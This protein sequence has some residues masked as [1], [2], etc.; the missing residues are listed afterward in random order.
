MGFFVA[1]PLKTKIYVYNKEWNNSAMGAISQKVQI[2]NQ[3]FTFS[4]FSADTDFSRLNKHFETRSVD[5]LLQWC[6]STFGDK[7]A[8]VTSFG[9]SGMVILDR[10]A[11]LNPGVRIITIDTDFLFEETYAL[12]EEVQRRYPIHLEVHRSSLSQE[13]Q[14]EK[15]GPKLWTTDPNHCCYL[16]KVIG[17]AGKTPRTLVPHAV[18]LG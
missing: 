7:V 11:Q 1:P 2:L 8:Q 4:T 14:A 10:L 18:G 6:L 17:E 9:A 16:R 13:L 15:Y 3:L 12:W 5:D